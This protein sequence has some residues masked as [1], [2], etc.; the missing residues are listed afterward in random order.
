VHFGRPATTLVHLHTCAHA[1]CRVKRVLIRSVAAGCLSAVPRNRVAL[2]SPRIA[3]LQSRTTC[4]HASDAC[5]LPSRA[6]RPFISARIHPRYRLWWGRALLS[7]S[8]CALFAGRLSY[9][10]APA[11]HPRPAFSRLH[12]S[13]SYSHR[14]RPYATA[15]DPIVAIGTCGRCSE[16]AGTHAMTPTSLS[17]TVRGA[18]ASV[19][20]R[21]CVPPCFI[22]GRGLTCYLLARDRPLIT[23][24][25]EMLAPASREAL[26]NIIR[27]ISCPRGMKSL[28]TFTLP[29]PR[30]QGTFLHFLS[31]DVHPPI[32]LP[33]P[34]PAR[35]LHVPSARARPPACF[36]TVRT[37]HL[38]LVG[39]L[40]P[41]PTRI[42]PHTHPSTRGRTHTDNALRRLVCETGTRGPAYMRAR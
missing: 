37:Q 17:Y 3:R 30:A 15:C 40:R 29:A 14:T 13:T 19:Y 32:H 1:Y 8:S 20:R 23:P 39:S 26:Y 2:R 6:R 18:L 36:S 16:A 38:L 28:R 21:R 35:A 10:L 4:A 9:T 42:S 5:S 7:S 25:T 41:G 24:V 27:R 12:Q 33:P 22:E 11:R 34:A 31:L